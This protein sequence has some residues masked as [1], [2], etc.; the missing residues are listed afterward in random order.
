M[1]VRYGLCQDDFSTLEISVDKEDSRR[2]ST[3]VSG[4]PG[5]LPPRLIGVNV[6]DHTSISASPQN[7]TIA[8]MHDA[9]RFQPGEILIQAISALMR[10]IDLAIQAAML[11]GAHDYTPTLPK[12]KA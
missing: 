4:W 8:E 10:H 6:E 12:V 7:E 5:K 3:T 11:S 1:D 9:C 2:S